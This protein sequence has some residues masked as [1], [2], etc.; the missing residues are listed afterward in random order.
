MNLNLI[1]DSPDERLRARLYVTNLGNSAYL[2]QLGA[3][4]AYGARFVAYAPPRQVG[5]EL[6]ANF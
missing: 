3:S 4:D 5:V 1:W 2:A 6:K